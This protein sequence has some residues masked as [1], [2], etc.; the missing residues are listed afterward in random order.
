MVMIQESS[1]LWKIAGSLLSV[2]KLT[3]LS[4]SDFF[5]CFCKTYV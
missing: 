1:I 4:L 3:D 2:L 5:F